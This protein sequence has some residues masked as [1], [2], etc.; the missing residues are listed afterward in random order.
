[1]LSRQWRLW[2][3]FWPL[4]GFPVGTAI[5]IE[6]HALRLWVSFQ[7][8]LNFQMQLGFACSGEFSKRDHDNISITEMVTHLGA[9]NV[10]FAQI[11]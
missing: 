3:R 5:Q 6:K 4:D 2:R 9:V 7:I 1:M 8:V 11:Y 10:L